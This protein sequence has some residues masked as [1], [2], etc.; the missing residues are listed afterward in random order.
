MARDN[1]DRRS[2]LV[3]EAAKRARAYLDGVNNRRVSP[4][5]EAVA[6]LSRFA[7]SMPVGPSDPAQVL[8]QL[9]EVGSPATVTTA[10]SRYFGFVIGGSLPA[11]LAANMLAAAWDQNVGLRVMSPIG[12]ALED[13]A[14]RWMIELFGFPQGTAGAFVTGATMAN[15]TCLAAARHTLLERKGWNVDGDGLFGAPPVPVVVGAEAHSTLF[16]ALSLLGMGRNRVITVPADAQGRF[17]V[18]VFPKLREPA[19]VC[20]QAGNV[21]TGAFDCAQEIIG[22]AKESGSWVHVDGA[23]GLWAVCAPR[24]AHLME[25]YCHADSWATDAHKW[26]NVPYDC[27]L[28]FIRNAVSAY[29][30]TNT[31]APYLPAGADREPMHWTP[32]S[33]RRARG[34]EVW[35]ALKSLGRSGLAEMIERN[36]RCAVRFADGLRLAGYDV[37]NDVVLNQVLVSFGDEATTRA[38]VE[39]V[40][41][42]GTCW[43]GGT[44]WQGRAAMR[45]SVSSWLTTAEDIDRSLEAVVRVSNKIR[46]NKRRKR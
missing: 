18:D 11:A 22:A 46:A 20:I 2:A 24:T 44:S 9:D 35:A 23:F 14:L 12:A 10:G 41:Q 40:Q 17:R 42:N 19:I 33:S 36:C 28:A 5:P 29:A 37:L 8:R 31:Q 6:A 27:G 39:A 13:V 43:C 30:T 25:G 38:V 1:K 16:K 7:E 34:V 32:E 4:T 26:L 21:N 15:F 45:I 3:G